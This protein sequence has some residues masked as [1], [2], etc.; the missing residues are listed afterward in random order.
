MG[1]PGHMQ[2]PFDVPE[3]RT[4]QDLISYFAKIVNYL[5]TNPAS[6]KFDGINVSFKLVDD[7]TK[8]SGKDFRMDRGTS[9]TESVVGMTANDAYKKW[10]EGHG[11]PPAIDDLLRVFNEALPLITTELKQLGLW[12]DPSKYFNTEYMKKGKTNVVEYQEPI[13]AIHGINQFYEK[14]AQKWRVAAGTSMDR[15][16][17][18]RPLGPTGKPVKEGST[19]VSYDRAVLEKI[20]EKVAPIAARIN[21][22]NAPNGYNL[23]GDTPANLAADVD[24]TEALNESFPI[25][26]SQGQV[27]DRTIGQ[28]LETAVNPAVPLPVDEVRTTNGKSIWAHS[29]DV[30]ITILNKVPLDEFLAVPEE[31]QQKAISGAVFNHATRLLGNAVKKA[32]DSKFGN[33]YDHEGLVIRGLEDRPVKVTGNFIVQG[34]GTSFRESIDK[35]ITRAISVIRENVTL[36]IEQEKLVLR[37]IIGYDDIDITH[38]G[39]TLTLEQKKVVTRLIRE[40]DDITGDRI[41]LLEQEEDLDLPDLPKVDLESL[42][43]VALVPGGFKPP[44]IGHFE[45]VRSFATKAD[46][47]FIIM[48]SGGKQ[49]RKINNKS[50]GYEEASMIW[51][52]YLEDAGIGNYNL[53][54]VGSGET[55]RVTGK[56][57]S[58]MQVAYDIMQLD[59]FPKQTVIMGASS[60]DSGRFQGIAEKYVPKNKEGQPLINLEVEEF[61]AYTIA[62]LTPSGE[63]VE[64][65]ASLMR[66]LV[67]QNDLDKFKQLIPETS[68]NRADEI[69]NLLSGDNATYM[70]EKKTLRTSHLFSLVEEYFEQEQPDSSIILE[71]LKLREEKT[72]VSKAGSERVSKEIG[73]L[74]KKD[75][76]PD[77]AAAI[78]YSMEKRGELKEED[79]QSLLSKALDLVTKESWRTLGQKHP[80][81][82]LFNKA[83][84]KDL[85]RIVSLYSQVGAALTEEELEEISMAGGGGLEGPGKKDERN[86]IIRTN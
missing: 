34:L 35:V 23:V 60:K 44:H 13:L 64:A 79:K 68:R 59:T 18:T 56:G 80:L 42:S 40:R 36:P 27:E 22:A 77:Q 61:P 63:E 82:V 66:S 46:M 74:I 37:K 55:S 85:S 84:E 30:Y 20:V 6:L 12:D 10:P 38:I 21:S 5:E 52:M 41:F 26:I 14:K 47:V 58:P 45:M 24:F 70:K 86:N 9:H 72:K 19:E 49:P 11:M 76:E 2:H 43:T 7:N 32:T 50:L 39:R 69:W 53:V 29:K 78:A 17:A 28:W 31:D 62:G 8:P 1:T 83:E 48:G 3:V 65:S 51:E 33:T 16:G 54:E 73:K 67:E 15:Q 57:A 25:T 81:F 71:N 75:T 4:G